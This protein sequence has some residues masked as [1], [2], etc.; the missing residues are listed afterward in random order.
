MILDE[1]LARRADAG[2]PVRIGLI[3]AG[4]MGTDI[5]TQVHLMRGLELGV[6]AEV[7]IDHAWAALDIAGIPRSKARQ[8]ESREEAEAAIAAGLIAITAKGSIACTAKGVDVIIDATGNPGVGA[9]LSI[10]AMDHG[11]HVVM[12]N[13][14]A[15]I[16]I[17]AYL[18][19]HAAEKGVVYSL[20]AGD[21]PAC[22]MELIHFAR[23]LG[24]PIVC[25]GK[26]KNNPL[27]FDA[28]PAEYEE[29]AK[30]RNM[31]ARMLVEFVDGS[32][33]M[34]EMVA[35]ANATG[36]IPDQPGMHGPAAGI[37]EL[38][39]TL[40]P[41]ADGGVL[42][43]PGRVD[44]SVGPGVAPGVFVI[45]K[46]PHPRVDERLRDLKVGK[47]PYYTLHRP[48]HLTSLETPMTA[49]RIALYK[50][51]DMT[52]LPNPVAEV[53]TIAKCD[54]APGT[55]LGKI[56]E[57]HYRGWAVTMDYSRANGLLPIGLAERA[58]VTKPIKAGE[59]LTYANCAPD[60]TMAI[61]K[62]RRKMDDMLSGKA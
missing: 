58:V 48:Y 22:T 62:L 9:E 51:P 50:K 25:A 30:R 6:V 20:A 54:L 26:G 52:P 47:G 36:L 38:D 1:D 31:N 28:T 44:Y 45:V 7:R 56:G 18:A 53:A 49:A 21:E 24:Y 43:A 15:D 39:K 27:K 42:S 34:I 8:V 10:E 46:A 60:E 33:T 29:E 59:Y 19:R 14:E 16:T 5:V 3:G 35:V 61:V 13:V 4:E 55:K 2:N 57:A 23:S 40:I 32:K 37:K 11:K 17:G 41:K 12:M